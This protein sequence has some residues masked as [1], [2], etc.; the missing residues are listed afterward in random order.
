MR[1]M[2]G[3]SLKQVHA[4]ERSN[5]I[6]NL[7]SLARLGELRR[8][9]VHCRIAV[10]KEDVLHLQGQH[11]LY[12]ELGRVYWLES[13]FHRPVENDLLQYAIGPVARRPLHCRTDEAVI[14]CRRY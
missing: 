5:C 11:L 14:R 6:T 7:I 1:D 3:R 8:D 4:K 12:S 2:P 10:C 13:S 9:E